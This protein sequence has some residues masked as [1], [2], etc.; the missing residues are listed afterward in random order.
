MSIDYSEKRL[1]DSMPAINETG[2]F[3]I[4]TP[5]NLDNIN[6]KSPF[7]EL[8]HV[9]A[10]DLFDSFSFLDQVNGLEEFE[11]VMKLMNALRVHHK[12]TYDHS[13]R[14]VAL[15]GIFAD[16]MLL[17]S[18][19]KAHLQIAAFLHDLGKLSVSTE[20]LNNKKKKGL[21]HEERKIINRHP[22]YGVLLLKD[23][24]SITQ[25]LLDGI[26]SHHEQWDGNGYPYGNKGTGRHPE[27][28]KMEREKIPYSGRFLCIIDCFDAMYHKRPYDTRRSKSLFEVFDELILNQGKQFDSYL[29]DEFINKVDFNKILA[30][31]KKMATVSMQL[32]VEENVSYPQEG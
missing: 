13:Q 26:I 7:F 10:K 2:S 31:Y 30:I 19:I 24:G 25:R 23:A 6:G 8:H 20:I 12:D 16:A 14:L 3:K 11:K 29:V 28:G 21:S 32:A 22:E 5:K 18:N 9:V 15:A 17:D 1:T 4:S 27:V